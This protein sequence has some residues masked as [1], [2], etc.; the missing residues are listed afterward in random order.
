MGGAV[1]Q[2]GLILG[3]QMPLYLQDAMATPKFEREGSD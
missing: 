1:R 2:W 3:L